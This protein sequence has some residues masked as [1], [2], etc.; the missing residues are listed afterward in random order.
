MEMDKN[1]ISNMLAFAD[2]AWMLF[3]GL[4][5]HF[6]S[7]VLTPQ[8]AVIATFERFADLP[9]SL[10][11]DQ[12]WSVQQILIAQECVG[13]DLRSRACMLLMVLWA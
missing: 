1:I 11:N 9:E 12:S 8:S 7:A 10:R 4:P 3:Y 2:N 13:V 6:A 5:S